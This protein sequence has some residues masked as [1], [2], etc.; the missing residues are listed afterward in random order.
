RS[1]FPRKREPRDFSCL[2]LGPRF[3][4]DD[5]LTCPQDFLTA[6]FAGKEGSAGCD[7]YHAPAVRRPLPLG[8]GRLPVAAVEQAPRLHRRRI[9]IIEAAGVDAVLVRIRARHVERVYA[10]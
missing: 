3:R 9:E 6:S 7:R 10:A 2:L 5:E 4:G 1:S 8:V